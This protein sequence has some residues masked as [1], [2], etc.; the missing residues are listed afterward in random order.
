MIGQFFLIYLPFLVVG[1]ALGTWV[2]GAMNLKKNIYK[3][4]LN[5]FKIYRAQMA[6]MAD[7]LEDGDLTTLDLKL[8][9]CNHNLTTMQ[10]QIQILQEMYQQSRD[11][12][13]LG[14]LTTLQKIQLNTISAQ[15]LLIGSQNQQGSVIEFGKN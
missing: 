14:L 10:N 4:K 6:R 9:I 7:L 1:I 15:S 12:A 3:D 11:P 8:E 2:A 13:L 5:S